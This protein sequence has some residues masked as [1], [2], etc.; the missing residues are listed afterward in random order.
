MRL[1]EAR[2]VHDALPKALWILDQFGVKRESRYGDVI[3]TPWP[4]TTIYSRPIERVIFWPE[5]DANPFFHLYEALWMVQGHND[6]ES[7]AKYAKRMR[8]FSDDGKTFHGAYGWRWRHHFHIDQIQVIIE[9]LKR[10]PD[11]RRCVLQMWDATVD[12]NRDGKD[13]PCN[14]AISFQRGING[15]LNMDVFNRSNDVIWGAYGANAVHM[16]FLQEY[17]ALGIGCEMGVY[18][19]HSVNWH[20]YVDVLK[21]VDSLRPFSGWFSIPVRLDNPYDGQVRPL[22]LSLDGDFDRVTRSIFTLVSDSDRDF[23]PSH[24]HDIRPK[25]SWAAMVECMFKAHYQLRLYA[26]DR[27]RFERA[28]DVLLTADQNIDWIAA[29]KQWLIR[30]MEKQCE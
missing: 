26:G 25:G 2:N 18:R 8:T 1:L 21:T 28:L 23:P 13:V 16:S 5:R 11:D 7:V 29:S 6:V 24:M 20:A 30:R 3:T 22:P 4:V 9:R 15:E 10:N 19:Q 17:I 12:L 14:I 27:S